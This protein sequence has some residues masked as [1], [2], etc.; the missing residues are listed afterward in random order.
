VRRNIIA[1]RYGALIDALY[2]GADSVLAE[3]EVTYEDGRKG[4][5]SGNLEIRD[6]KTFPRRSEVGHDS[7]RAA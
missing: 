5:I 1:E 7:S 6:V 3:I 2:G 4:K